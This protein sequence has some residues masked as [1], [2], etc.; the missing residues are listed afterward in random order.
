MLG[1]RRR[2]WTNIKP[3]LTGRPAQT[4]TKCWR[5]Q[6][7]VT[8]L[9][10][11]FEMNRWDSRRGPNTCFHNPARVS[12]PRKFICI[13]PFTGKES[14]HGFQSISYFW[15][16]LNNSVHFEDVMASR[17]VN[18][19]VT[20]RIQGDTKTRNRQKQLDKICGLT[21]GSQHDFNNTYC[22]LKIGL[23]S[24]TLSNS[25]THPYEV[26]SRYRDPQVYFCCIWDRHVVILAAY[27]PKK[28][29]FM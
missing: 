13:P 26:V 24:F 6:E 20:Q 29:Y 4:G 5:I 16:R 17:G 3:T 11:G 28:K 18:S 15:I 10:S 1:Q 19:G 22:G 8:G 25:N 9:S 27:S 2:R 21:S 23:K 14:N 12:H 7:D